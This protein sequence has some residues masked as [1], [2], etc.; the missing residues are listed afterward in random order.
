MPFQ[1]LQPGPRALGRW[2]GRVR[3]RVSL[4][5]AC[6]QPSPLFTHTGPPDD[7]PPTSDLLAFYNV[8]RL[9]GYALAAPKADYTANVPGDARLFA[10]P[11]GLHQ[12]AAPGQPS[13]SLASSSGP[14]TAIAPLAA[15]RAGLGPPVQGVPTLPTGHLDVAGLRAALAAGLGAGG[16]GGGSGGGGGRGL[17]EADRGTVLGE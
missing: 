5:C 8:R 1:L 9:H 13:S 10:G 3:A 4:A 7:P 16:G 12:A 11:G 2:E 6:H 14:H 17:S 15:A